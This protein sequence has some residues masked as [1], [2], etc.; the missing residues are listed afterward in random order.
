MG[1][2]MSKYLVACLAIA[3]SACGGG[4]ANVKDTPP[5]PPPPPPPVDTS[6]MVV[7]SD[8]AVAFGETITRPIV[9][10]NG[11]ALDNQGAIGGD[12][13]IAVEAKAPSVIDNHDGGTIRG[14]T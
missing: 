11:A 10:E 4:G 3:L 8:L 5:P 9:L 6:P 13:D 1:N 2:A 14:D 12:V 7:G